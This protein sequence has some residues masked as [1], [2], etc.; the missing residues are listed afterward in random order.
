MAQ[1]TRR[2]RRARWGSGSARVG[3]TARTSAIGPPGSGCALR[4]SAPSASTSRGTSRASPPAARAASSR[5]P[6]VEQL[7][8]GVEQ[9]GDG[10]ARR[11][12]ARV[13]RRPEARV[14]VEHDDLGAGGRGQRGPVVAR[15]RVDDH[16]LR[17]RAA[18][19]SRS[20]GSSRCSSGAE[21]WSTV[22]IVKLTPRP[23]R[24]AGAARRP[25]APRCS[26][27]RARARRR[28]GGRAGRRRPPMRSSASASASTSPDR[29]AQRGVA[30]RLGEAR[31]GP[32][33]RPACRGRRPRAPTSPKPSRYDGATTASAPA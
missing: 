17:R 5:Q 3:S 6:G 20:E 13:A 4:C 11:G 18:A 8:V 2:G 9:D 29:H 19:C 31:R 27:R 10:V 21:S 15:A 24:A 25:P 22:T 26:G 30:Q 28:P 32:R 12:H 7:A 16:E 1:P 33:P 14:A 23:A